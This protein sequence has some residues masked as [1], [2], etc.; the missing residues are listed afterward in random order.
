MA[1][2]ACT[3]LSGE[4]SDTEKAW[5]AKAHRQDKN[6]WILLRIQGAPFERGFQRGFLTAGEIADFLNTL[7]H[8]SKHSTA[9][10]Q[11]FFVKAAKRL[12]RNRI[13]EEFME[14][15]RGMVEGMGSAGK[16]VTLDQML[17]MNGFIDILWYWWPKTKDTKPGPG[18]GC[19]AFIATKGAT[20]DG[21]IVMAHNSW[22][23]YA[24]LQFCN[25]LVDLVP[26]KGH[27]ILMQTWGPC[28]Y[29]ATDFFI[30]GA[31]LV[32]TETTIGG[33]NG[34][35]RKGRPVFERA[36]RAMQY[37]NSIDEWAQ[38]MI[39]DNNGAYANSWLLGDI[40]TNE[41]ARL[42]LGLKHYRLEKKKD[43]TYTGSNVA[44]D[45]GILR[46]ETDASDDDVRNFR[47]ARKVAW[48]HLMNKVAGRIDAETA[49]RM[50]ADHYDAYLEREQPSSRTLCGHWAL[51]DGRVPESLGAFLP[52]GAI[53]G[54]VT[55]ADMAKNWT[56]WAK[57]GASCDIGFDAKAFL[58]KHPQYG[59]LA[60]YLRD[61]PPNPWTLFSF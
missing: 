11:D 31:G 5:L 28:I 54:K 35:E 21:K 60:G 49:K 8:T 6:G 13:S 18:P 43:G 58:K 27:R 32:G 14:E 16:T 59:W 55:T 37:A 20:A 40:R 1:L 24:E 9:R 52:G 46:D 34:Y 29:S 15:M 23:M 39:E 42:E 47:V 10:E 22:A 50:L 44:D 2:S 53:D 7:T 25:I 57:W 19:S 56:V 30:T 41:I 36:R 17:F 12:F 26:D 45:L 61:L 51:D 48:G 4:L 33:F 38:I 3:L